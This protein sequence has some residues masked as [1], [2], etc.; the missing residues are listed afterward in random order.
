M[1]AFIAANEPGLSPLGRCRELA[2]SVPLAPS[3][4]PY[5]LATGSAVGNWGA[6][7]AFCACPCGSHSY[8]MRRHRLWD[9]FFQPLPLV[10]DLH[11]WQDRRGPRADARQPWGRGLLVASGHVAYVADGT[12]PLIDY[13]K[14]EMTAKPRNDWRAESI[15]D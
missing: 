3:A 1:L 2:A 8:S 6:S 14:K 13:M 12:N 4:E 10:T 7:G 9:R 5:S 11:R 15:S